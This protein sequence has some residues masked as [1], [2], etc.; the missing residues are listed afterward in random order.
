MKIKAV[1]LALLLVAMVVTVIAPVSA[2][3]PPNPPAELPPQWY[4]NPGNFPKLYDS[5]SQ[6]GENGIADQNAPDALHGVPEDAPWPGR[7]EP[8]PPPNR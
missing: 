3:I 1:I 4:D 7:P 5:P 6:G 8:P 2:M